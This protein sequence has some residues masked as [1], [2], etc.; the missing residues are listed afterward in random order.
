MERD[1]FLGNSYTHLFAGKYNQIIFDYFIHKK[2]LLEV[3][4]KADQP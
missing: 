2:L 4:V 3:A 1:D